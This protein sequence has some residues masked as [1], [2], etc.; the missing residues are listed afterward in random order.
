MFNKENN[1]NSPPLMVKSSTLVK[2]NIKED[3]KLISL[4]ESNNNFKQKRKWKIISNH[5]IGK[6]GKQCFSRY[7]R[8]KSNIK[9][10]RWSAEEDYKIKDLVT[11]YNFN[12][13]KISK[14]IYNRT[15]K[16]IRDR[17]INYLD[18]NLNNNPFTIL[19]N[20]KIINF[21][22]EY[23]KQ[24]V[25]LSKVIR[26]KSPLSI[27]NK[28]FSLLRANKTKI[29]EVNKI[30]LISKEPK[31]PKINESKVNLNFNLKIKDIAQEEEYFTY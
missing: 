5:F 10:G 31:E 25:K 13:A 28:Y 26:G 3:I 15:P 11:L 8:I 7:N 2:W 1:I 29:D 9:K 18:P 27:K 4:V 12:W 21:V 14:L 22:K 23:G 6:S 16:Q 20:K 30:F 24:W 19:E 17:Y